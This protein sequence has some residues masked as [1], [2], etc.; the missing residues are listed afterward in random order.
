VDEARIRLYLPSSGLVLSYEYR[1]ERL[2]NKIVF[3]YESNYSAPAE[4]RLLVPWS[5]FAAVDRE[6]GKRILEVRRDDLSCSFRW[7][8]RNQDDFIVVDTDLKKHSLEI[9]LKDRE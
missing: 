1:P 9:A 3:S 2:D 7:L 5:F 4:V 6:A 8:S